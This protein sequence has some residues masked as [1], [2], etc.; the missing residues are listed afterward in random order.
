MN[1]TDH[2]VSDD[3]ILLG[4]PIIKGTRI[5]IEH[6]IGLLAQGWTEKQILENYPQLTQEI[7]TIVDKDNIRQ[8]KY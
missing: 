1:W 8:R 6:V 2:I 4:K 3:S 7:L 5:S